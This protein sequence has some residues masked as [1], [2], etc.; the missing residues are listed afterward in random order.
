MLEWTCQN[1]GNLSSLVGL[2]LAFYAT[3]TARTAKSAADNAVKRYNKE[4]R[5]ILLAGHLSQAVAAA[6]RLACSRAQRF[7]K[8]DCD[9]LR[10]NLVHICELGEL[11]TPT[12]KNFQL[13][14]ARLRD[15]PENTETSQKAVRELIDDLIAL[16]S[17]LT[18]TRVHGRTNSESCNAT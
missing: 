8:P 6:R 1:W 15:V 18:N 12:R 14:L 3:W 11:A 16:E 9:L 4:L 2:V 10:E 17:Q 7:P 13:H 5:R